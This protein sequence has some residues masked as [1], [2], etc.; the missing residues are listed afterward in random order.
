MSLEGKFVT[1]ELKYI[2]SAGPEVGA[3]QNK[4]RVLETIRP[5]IA[6][7]ASEV[8]GLVAPIGVQVVNYESIV[9]PVPVQIIKKVTATV[10]PAPKIA[11]PKL[12]T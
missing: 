2:V 11:A 1:D 5:R 7:A 4:L 10:V 6:T 12:P 3:L 8:H 9:E